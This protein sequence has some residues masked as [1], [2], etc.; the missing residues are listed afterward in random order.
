MKEY[1]TGPSTKPF[2][3]YGA[4]GSGKSSL[5]SMSAYKSLKEWLAPSRPLLFI[6]FCGTTPNSTSL[7]PLLKSL[8]QQICY[9]L[10]IPLESIPDD[11]VPVTAYFKELLKL[12]TKVQPFLIFF[13]SVDELVGSKDA[14]IFSWLPV[15]FPE[16]C[17]IV[18]S[19]TY[20]ENKKIMR[21]NLK[22]LKALIEEDS[23]FVQIQALGKDLAWNIMKL[24]MK[25]VGRDLNNYQWRVVA[26]A[27]DLCTLPIFCKLVFQEVCRWKSYTDPDLT[28]L[29]PN[30]MSSVFQ[31]FERVESKH[32]WMMVS[33]ALSYVTASK[34]GI[35]EPEI[36]DLISLDDKVLDDI[37]QYHLPPERRMPPLLWTRVRSD[38][39][40]YLADRE[41]DGVSVI[42]WYHKT[43][44]IAA[45][46][47]YFETEE[48]YLY[49]HSY[50]SDYFL[51]TYGG[52]ISKP[53]KYTEIQK[54]MFKLKSKECSADRKV[55]TQPLYYLDKH[56]KR[57]RFNLRKLSELPYQLV[58]CYR[59]KD[60]Y[61]HVL[62][63]Y[64]W[65]LYKLSAL[66]LNEVLE[67][68]EDAVSHI[69][70]K[71][72][73]KEIILVADSI[74]LGGA[75]LKQYPEMLAAQLV[76]RLLP[77][78]CNYTNIRHL[79]QQCDQ[80]GIKEN[81]LIPTFHCLHTPGGPLKYSMEGHQ[82]AIFAMK[83]TSDKRYIISVSNRFITFDAVTS[84]LVR[85]VYPGVKGLMLGLELSKDDKYA[86]A[87]TNNNQIVLLNMLVGEFIV[88]NNPFTSDGTTLESVTGIKILEGILIVV[89][90][91]SWSCYDMNGNQLAQE[92]SPSAKEIFALK[93]ISTNNFTLINHTGTEEQPQFEIKK[94]LDGTFGKP[95]ISNSVF[96]INKAQT[97]VYICKSKKSFSVYAYKLVGLN[98]YKENILEDNAEPILMLSLPENE[99]W[100]IATVLRKD[101]KKIFFSHRF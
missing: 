92:K 64:R 42:N 38:L 26:N 87:F 2:V 81:A 36:E 52:G 66:P 23:N 55:P 48:D 3:M 76:G 95:V 34:N 28:V 37:Y 1:I 20:E 10:F 89:G 45:K 61:D 62:F 80:E 8:C 49:F 71:A 5:L 47:R 101:V 24:W 79:L 54:H 33:H 6:R 30:V 19:V 32:G 25:S 98:W 15:K 82:F 27:L 51:G 50:L 16:H 75:I 4:G 41:A 83:L 11:T 94:C 65:L 86:A 99:D 77:E 93:V 58:R 40:G 90:Q 72:A 53:F 43:F 60:L 22:N 31:L 85:Q 29:Q 73:V 9:N 13:D 78:R 7:G 100:C 74:R 46:E 67:D 68:F 96:T 91:F 21:Q 69:K 44:K 63:N 88:I 18:I 56:G 17:K 57:S 97:K 12:A 14:N 59:Y 35:S 84:D 70:D 39:P